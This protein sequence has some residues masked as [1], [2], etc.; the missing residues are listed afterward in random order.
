MSTPTFPVTPV[1][2]RKERLTAALDAFLNNDVHATD[3]AALADLRREE[4]PSIESNWSRISDSG[5]VAIIRWVAE[6]SEDRVE[7][8]FGRL[9]RFALMDASPAVRQLAL[10]SL[11][12]DEGSDLPSRLVSILR[13]D[14]SADVKAEAAALLGRCV[15][16]FATQG[17]IQADENTVRSALLESWRDGS[18][19]PVVRRRSLESVSGFGADDEIRRAIGDAFDHDDGFIAV[20]AVRAMGRTMCSDYLGSILAEMGS[21]NAEFRYEAAIAAGELGDSRAVSEL[22]SLLDDEDAEVR[23][24]AMTALGR[25][26]GQAAIRALSSKLDGEQTGSDAESL[27]EALEYAMLDVDPSENSAPF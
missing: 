15:D 18:Q 12:E 16:R 25:I 1:D 5:R 8:T 4:M 20:G 10:R 3:V 23:H 26:G 22:A 27:A 7:L 17:D 13:D 11:W 24:A 2:D 14:P 21:D 19:A 9:L 6:L